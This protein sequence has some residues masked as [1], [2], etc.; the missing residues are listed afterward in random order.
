MF[1]FK[2]NGTGAFGPDPPLAPPPN[3]PLQV[4]SP[5]QVALGET[6]YGRRCGLCHGFDAVSGNIL[7]D[8]RRSAFLTSPPAWQSVVIG[9]ALASRGMISWRESITPAQAE[10]VRAF[11]GERARA[12]KLELDHNVTR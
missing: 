11:V 10:A 6:V 3:P 7:P 2:L 5:A 4:A 9:G 1:A 12:L 8:L